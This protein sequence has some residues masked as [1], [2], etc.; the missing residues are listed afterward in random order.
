MIAFYMMANILSVLCQIPLVAKANPALL[1]PQA[2]S[3]VPG[4]PDK[5]FPTEL[6]DYFKGEWSGA[7][8]FT[9]SGK[10]V[11]SDLSFASGLDNE[12]LIVHQKERAPNTYEFIALW[13]FEPVTGNLVML[14]TSG[15]NSGAQIFRTPS[16]AWQD[17]KIVFQSSTEMT[18]GSSL[19]RFT[20]ERK[21]DA[22]FAV[23]YEMSR[24]GKTWHTGDT[25]VFTR[26]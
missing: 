19:E 14:M 4:A 18:G 12:C 16:R 23:T 10:D 22:S 20:F 7:G 26:K 1:P 9:Y 8:K 24:D 25:Q 11:A 3:P 6:V 5:S 2:L 15:R 17:G 13:S 21:S